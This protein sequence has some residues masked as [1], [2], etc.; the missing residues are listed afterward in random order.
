MTPGVPGPRD[1]QAPEPLWSDEVAEVLIDQTRLQT[2][3]RELAQ[4]ICADH[5]GGDLVLVAVLKGALVFAADLMRCLPRQVCL[6]CV[7][8]ASYGCGDRPGEA[9]DL[10]LG[11]S[12]DLAGRQVLV[13]EDIVDTGRT[14]A[15]LTARLQAMNPASLRTCCLLDKPSRRE[16]PFEADYVGFEIPDKFVV[17]YGLDYREKYRNLRDIGTLAPHVYS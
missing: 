6:E 9:V 17:G 13:V 8:V 11:P 12:L 2:R 10:R 16:V 4:A 14:L 3:V 1:G 7:C 15:A 5:A